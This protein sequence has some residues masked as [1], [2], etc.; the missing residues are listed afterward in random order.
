[1]IVDTSK[2]FVHLF[3]KDDLHVILHD[4]DLRAH[5]HTHTHIFM[6]CIYSSFLN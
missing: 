3:V 4:V 2:I 5:T 6:F 1:M